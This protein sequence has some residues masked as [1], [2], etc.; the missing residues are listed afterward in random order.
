MYISYT[1]NLACIRRRLT[2][3]KKYD[4][5]DKYSKIWQR[6]LK[7]KTNRTIENESRRM[8]VQTLD[9]ESA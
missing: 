5:I 7:K 8:R 4:T 9:Y 6:G 2:G 1:K 3:E